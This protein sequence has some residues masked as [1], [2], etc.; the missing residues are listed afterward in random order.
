MSERGRLATEAFRDSTAG[1][2]PIQAS[3]YGGP[4]LVL[5]I[6]HGSLDSQFIDFEFGCGEW[7]AGSKPRCAA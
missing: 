4:L 5:D 7:M 1:V 3:R 2:R 6:P